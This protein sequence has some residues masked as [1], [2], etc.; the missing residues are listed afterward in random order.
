NIEVLRITHTPSGIDKAG[1][2]AW[3]LPRLDRA[4]PIVEYLQIAS[5]RVVGKAILQYERRADAA[6]GRSETRAGGESQAGR[7]PI[8]P[9]RGIGVIDAIPAT[10][11]G[12]RSNSPGEPNARSESLIVG[13]IE[14]GVGVTRAVQK[15]HHARRS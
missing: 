14:A 10:D 12:L 13:V 6:I 2:R 8:G 7:A 9:Q 4:E 1:R 3:R 5:Q 11:Y 15:Q